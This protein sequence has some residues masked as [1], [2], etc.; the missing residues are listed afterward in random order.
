MET[1]WDFRSFFRTWVETF[2]G[3]PVEVQSSSDG[4]FAVLQL[5]NRKSLCRHD[6]A[7]HLR[8]NG[9]NQVPEPHSNIFFC[10]CFFFLPCKSKESLPF[11]LNHVMIVESGTGYDRNRV[12]GAASSGMAVARHFPCYRRHP[13]Q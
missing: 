2:R 9:V 6:N 7:M 12:F 3:S 13:D 1:N 5:M 10:C 8:R 4:I 11:S